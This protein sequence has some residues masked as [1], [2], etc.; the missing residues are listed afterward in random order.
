MSTP[1][2]STT[3]EE[4]LE[5]PAHAGI[6]V[7][8]EQNG[9]PPNAVSA[10]GNQQALQAASTDEAVLDSQVHSSPSTGS[11]A[12]NTAAYSNGTAAPPS[13][14]KS[15]PASMPKLPQRTSK[16]PS[17][18]S[19]HTD[20]AAQHHA[21]KPAS[22]SQQQPA[23]SSPSTA[24]S[25]QSAANNYTK[26]TS[27]STSS[28]PPVKPQSKPAAGMP[29]LP[30]RHVSSSSNAA[31]NT[32]VIDPKETEATQHV[33]Q[34]VHNIRVA[35][36]RAASR[37]GYNHDNGIV[38]QVLYRLYL[39]EKLHAP[40]RKGVRR[41]DPA[42][43]AAKEAARLEEEQGPTSLLDL[44]V[45]ILLIGLAGTGKTQ[46]IHSLLRE[47]P[48]AANGHSASA[49]SND[50]TSSGSSRAPASEASSSSSKASNS[51]GSSSGVGVDAFAGATK[52]V[53]VVTGSVMGI[54]L[55]M[56]DTPGMHASAA[57]FK[58]NIA[59]LRAIKAAYKQHKP[60]L[61]IYVD[62]FDQPSRSGGEM[63]VLQALTNTL[64]PGIWLNTIVALTHAGG[65]PPSTARG[66]LSYDSYAQQRSHL[67]QLIIRNASGDARLMNPTAFVE[68]HPD[69]RTNPE[70]QYII[71][72]GIPW[73]QHLLLMVVSAKL[74][75][76]T[77][78]ALQMQAA[79]GSAAATGSGG[80]L[81]NPSN[82]A[83]MHQLLRQPVLPVRYI[84]TGLT[85]FN[86]PLTY[87][88]HG[89]I[90][91][92]RQAQ[93]TLPK[94]SNLCSKK[95]MH[96]QIRFR[97]LQLSQAARQQQQRADMLNKAT[98]AGGKMMTQIPA[99]ANRTR[100]SVQPAPTHRYRV[101]EA[102]AGWI[103]KPHIE[104]HGM[105]NSDG[106][107]GFMCDKQGVA[108]RSPG[109]L[110][111]G[112]PYRV[113]ANA[114][115]SK[116]QVVM[117]AHG[118]MS[119]YHDL[120]G[121]TTTTLSMDVQASGAPGSPDMLYIVRA[122]TQSRGF[123]LKCNAPTVGILAA[124]LAQGAYPARGPAAFGVRLQDSLRLRGPRGLPL[125]ID[126]ALG[127]VF[128]P[129]GI[130]REDAWGG[131][132]EVRTDARQLV[133]S[134]F[135]APLSLSSSVMSHKGEMMAAVATS[136]QVRTGA[137]SGLGGKL[138][139]N[140][141]GHGQLSVHVKSNEHHWWGLVGLVPLFNLAVDMLMSG[142]SDK[143]HGGGQQ[144]SSA[145]GQ[146][147]Q[148]VPQVQS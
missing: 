95:E 37:L 77:E 49:S 40:V 45:K 70:G 106:V 67:L 47:P 121:A 23:E 4:Q 128:C 1:P 26:S 62:R 36:I 107:E 10:A 3:S 52:K 27:A 57:G 81:V 65:L 114:Q 96:R 13:T 51:I 111:Q 72:N 30:A 58:A 28:K 119:F 112:A 32:S 118:D 90:M 59:V 135:S 123:P 104:P 110:L 43:V 102:G 98:K 69:C 139:I 97:L 34:K 101:P 99:T 75:A 60:D 148:Y 87:Q 78:A 134:R 5:Q 11:P 61:V 74:L 89:A 103:I 82:A 64:G 41:P 54:Q 71:P 88:D 16:S 108:F 8:A 122:D 56:I 14:T 125:D 25:S 129:S 116:E 22:S 131:N 19:S 38:K 76:D 142:R 109:D 63:A 6:G 143:K 17:A 84:M 91:E 46:L 73:Q 20:S 141:K 33:R 117:Q 31:T 147:G 130:E 39:A 53:E 18:A 93:Q 144:S 138:Q 83:A 79:G 126:T 92:L 113:S 68:S 12:T 86:Q 2:G 15:K 48:S 7:T 105:D 146:Q 124:H 132:L 35:L 120:P 66:Q 115:A 42:L 21:P 50:T 127:K 140:N 9:G 55:T 44:D 85:Q 94:I 133:G 80:P 29:S 137:K 145:A 24:S 136:L 100:P